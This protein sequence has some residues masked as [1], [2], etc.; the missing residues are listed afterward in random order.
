[1]TAYAQSLHAFKDG[2]RNVYSTPPS[3]STTLR[4]PFV[5]SLLRYRQWHSRSSGKAG[6]SGSSSNISSNSSSAGLS[7][8][9]SFG[10]AALVGRSSRMHNSEPWISM[11]DP[12]GDVRNISETKCSGS[13][14]IMAP[15][16]G[17]I[18]WCIYLPLRLNSRYASMILRGPDVSKDG[19][20]DAGAKT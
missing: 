1:M 15:C 11:T 14:N 10:R 9:A 18:Y 7:H 20:M 17:I 2:N 5:R 4:V 12:V 19:H 13:K 3:A 6:S 8:V 16:T